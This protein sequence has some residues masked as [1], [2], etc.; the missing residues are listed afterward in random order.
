MCYA[1]C[2]FI[3]VAFGFNAAEEVPLSPITFCKRNSVYFNDCLKTAIQE[4]WSQFVKELPEFDSPPLDPFIFEFGNAVFD[5]GAVHRVANVSNYIG[6]FNITAEDL[7]RPWILKGHVTN[8]IWTVEDFYV[9][10][11]IKKINALF[12]Y[13]IFAIK[14]SMILS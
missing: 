3:V 10:P 4:A 13:I 12:W 8:D 14:S 1:L 6:P 5:R 2:T 9:A 7:Q 11:S